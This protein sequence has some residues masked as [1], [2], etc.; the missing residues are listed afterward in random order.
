MRRAT[1]F[2]SAL[3]CTALVAASAGCGNSGSSS[4]SAEGGVLNLVTANHPWTEAVK[5]LGLLDEYQ[6][7]TGTKVSIES[8]AEDQLTQQ[9]TVKLNAPNSEID[10]VMYRPPQE[11]K[12][13]VQNG[14]LVELADLTKD[15]SFDWAD[16][17]DGPRGTVTI[18]NKVYGAPIVTEREILYYRKSLLQQK[19]IEVPKSLDDLIAAAQKLDDKPGGVAGFIARGK[20]ANAVT[21]FS[22]YLYGYGGDFIKD[23]RSAINTPEAIKAFSVYGSLLRDYGPRPADSTLQMN[24]P[25]ALAVFVQGKAAMYTDA[26]SIVAGMLDK[27]KSKISDDLGFA[28]FPAGPA[29]AKPYQVASWALGVSAKAPHA[30]AAKKFISWIASKDNVL[31]LQQKA[32]P[33]PRLSAWN[34]ADGT[35]GFPAEYVTALNATMKLKTTDHDR[36]QVVGV[37][38]SREIVGSVI[39]ASIQ[40]KDV[41]AA[42][43]AADKDLTEFLKTDGK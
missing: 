36:P 19:G 43:A 5:S 11:G 30:A 15:S 38:R 34:S 25:E 14:W 28:P 42:A 24:W 41:A 37:A 17:Q 40:G 12:Q 22:S 10:V 20:Q 1:P 39:V 27:Q 29:G 26:D 23:G 2:L 31:K 8:F 18:D 35:K 9:L 6:K 3:L 13:F 4:D 16:F 7:V 32:V 21:Q 33:G